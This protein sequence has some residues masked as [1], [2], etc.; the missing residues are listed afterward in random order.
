[1]ILVFI[2]GVGTIEDSF[3]GLLVTLTIIALF[4][5]SILSF[6]TLFPQ[7]QGVSFNSLRENDAY[8]TISQMDLN[9]TESLSTIRNNSESAFNEWDITQGYMGTNTIKQ[10]SSSGVKGYNNNIFSTIKLMAS[11]VFGSNSPFVYAIGVLL[12]LSISVITY[13]IYKLVRQGQ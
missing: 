8:L 6:I 9:T 7:E 13:M 12:T 4:T 5:T 3:K 2:G 11:K 1:L 10:G